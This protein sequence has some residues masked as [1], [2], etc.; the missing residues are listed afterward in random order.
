M[1]SILLQFIL[2]GLFP[3]IL[4][5][6]CVFLSFF[7]S[8]M[9]HFPFI[10]KSVF[11]FLALYFYPYFP[12]V[13]LIFYFLSIVSFSPSWCP[14]SC[15]I[16]HSLLISLFSLFY[17]LTTYLCPLFKNKKAHKMDSCSC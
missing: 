13:S 7:L 10:L 1:I 8:M 14:P 11:N 12:F 17:S 6:H 2:Y 15:A 4:P 3:G 9:L 5:S 16:V